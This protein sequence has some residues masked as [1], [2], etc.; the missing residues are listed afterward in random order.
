MELMGTAVLSHEERGLGDTEKGAG[1]MKSE[2]IWPSSHG[3]DQGGRIK[4]KRD[5]SCIAAQVQASMAG[6]TAAVMFGKYSLS[7]FGLT[8]SPVINE[9]I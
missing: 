2:Q 4:V 3:H 7:V 1:G 5:S 6:R 9:N 8:N